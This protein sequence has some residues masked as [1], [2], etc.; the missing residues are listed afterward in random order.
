MRDNALTFMLVGEITHW[1][2]LTRLLR[3]SDFD[4][5]LDLDVF[6]V[7]HISADGVAVG[8]VVFVKGHHDDMAGLRIVAQLRPWAIT[9]PLEPV[10]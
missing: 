10:R 1:D 5:F 9:D 8:R 6:L 4:V 7:P 2:P 3:I